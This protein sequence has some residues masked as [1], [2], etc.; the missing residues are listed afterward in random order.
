MTSKNIYTNSPEILP[1]TEALLACA[2]IL[3]THFQRACHG[4]SVIDLDAVIE[5]TDNLIKGRRNLQFALSGGTV[6][7][8]SQPVS[9]HE[10]KPMRMRSN[11]NYGGFYSGP[12][13]FLSS[14]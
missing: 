7:R 9:E 4:L 11:G 3:S 12:T 8:P 2:G 13:V 5:L 14:C 1:L 6:L 10:T